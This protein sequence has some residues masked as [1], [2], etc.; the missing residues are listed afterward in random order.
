[1]S[2]FWPN[3]YHQLHL[4]LSTLM[5]SGEASDKNI[6]GMAALIYVTL[7]IDILTDE[8]H[9]ISNIISLVYHYASQS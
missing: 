3:V 8:L 5:T 2:S 7:T 6:V 1:M 9:R 4:K